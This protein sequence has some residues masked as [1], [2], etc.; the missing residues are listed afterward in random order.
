M[1]KDYYKILGVHESDSPDDIKF[2]YRKLARRWHPDVAG[3]GADVL[4][5]FKEINEAYQVLSDKIK[6]EEYDRARKFYNYAKSGDASKSN[7]TQAAYDKSDDINNSYFKNFSKNINEWFYGGSKKKESEYKT[8]NSVPQRGE[9]VYTEIEISVLD[10]INGVE[11]VINILQT[12]SCPS[13]KGRKFIN[14]GVCIHC[15]GKGYLS[16][17]KKFTVKIPA[18]IKNGAKIRLAGEGA[19]GKNGGSNG[20]LYIK[21][22]VQND[23]NYKTEGLNILKT[24]YITPYEAVLG[25]DIEIMSMQG[26]YTVKVMPNTQNGQKIRLSGCGIMQNDSVGDMIIT[27]EIRIPKNLSKEEIDLYKRLSELSAHNIRDSI[28]D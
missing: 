20:D 18:G 4:S 28:Y 7:N 2:A 6:K 13:C 5:K 23:I 15:N 8:E 11:K 9:D 16:Q 24:V 14:N 10:A 27:L 21:I 12:N 26:K 22:K 17:H 25:A 19:H 1:D 3:S